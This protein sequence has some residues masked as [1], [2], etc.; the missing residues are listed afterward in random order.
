MDTV[1][2]LSLLTGLA[3]GAPGAWVVARGQFRRELTESIAA[4]QATVGAAQALFHRTARRLGE[5]QNELVR[6][7]EELARVGAELKRSISTRRKATAEA[8]RE[9]KLADHSRQVRDHLTKL[10][11]NLARNSTTACAHLFLAHGNGE[12]VGDGPPVPFAP[13][14]AGIDR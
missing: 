12:A 14:A 8:T 7:R 2:L 3:V 11:A 9:Q 10:G 6:S 5:V 1:V 13:A 4:H